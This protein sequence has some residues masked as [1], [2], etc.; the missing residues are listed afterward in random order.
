MRRN[1]FAVA[2][3]LPLCL[4]RPGAQRASAIAAAATSTATALPKRIMHGGI[5][6][7]SGDTPGYPPASNSSPYCTWWFDADGY[8][9]CEELAAF[10]DITMEDFVRWVS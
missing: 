9:T 10:W 1:L 7:L 8:E 5:S 4:A 6:L 2:A 3:C